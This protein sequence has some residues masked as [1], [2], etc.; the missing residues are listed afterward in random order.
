MARARLGGEPLS[1]SGAPS[2]HP[3]ISK[4]KI[5][6]K[7]RTPF[8]YILILYGKG[9]DT[10]LCLYKLQSLSESANHHRPASVRGPSHP[11]QGPRTCHSPPD[12]VHHCFCR[13]QD[14]AGSNLSRALLLAP[15]PG[16][17]TSQPSLNLG[18]TGCLL[19]LSA[20]SW[21]C[22][23]AASQHSVCGW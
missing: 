22:G 8:L 4:N 16:S 14:L 20:H 10:L 18:A 21:N 12:T 17:R 23:I 11:R 1:A 7:P 2:N 19:V 5:R 13:A 6:K 3:T 9:E 15:I